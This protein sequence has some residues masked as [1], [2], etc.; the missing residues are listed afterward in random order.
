MGVSNNQDCALEDEAPDT[1]A[2]GPRETDHAWQKAVI[3]ALPSHL[4]VLDRNGR[5]VAH[6]QAWE[7][8]VLQSPH[9]SGYRMGDNYLDTLLA[10][11]GQGDSLAA[12]A[13]SGLRSV[14]NGQCPIFD[15]ET[16]FCSSDGDQR[17]YL[18]HA[19]PIR[20]HDGCVVTYLDITES[21][22]QAKSLQQAFDEVKR[23]QEQLV[24]SEKMASIGQLT[25]GVAHEINNPIGYLSSNL[26]SMVQYFDDV[27]RMVNAYEEASA[28][29]TDPEQVS[30]LQQAKRDIDI[31][32]VLDDIPKLLAES[33]EG[34][35]R[36][37][38]IVQDLKDFA[39]AGSSEDWEW[40][41]LRHSLARTLN[42][43]H[44]ELKYK[45]EVVQAYEDIP[46][47]RCL[48]GQLN[49]VFM[50]LL[51]NAAHAIEK[52][53]QVSVKTWHEGDLVWVEIADTGSGMPPEVIGRIF[54]PFFTTKPVGKGTG[55]GLSISY[56]IVKK[57]GGR[58][59]VESEV[60]RGT[61]FRIALPVNGPDG[62][63]E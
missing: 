27:L 56:G 25:A 10:L 17:C 49:Q 62:E 29:L 55:L 59:E 33:Q 28:S 26:T 46:E 45:A 4:A 43:V 24:Q 14:L 52:D 22:Q 37:R 61:R 23:T 53:G 11:A 54:E 38:K 18:M 13:T 35:K 12:Q 9:K 31:D 15:L 50:N 60:G 34:T 30:R 58:I 21:K 48:P 2:G 47:I 63:D 6:N 42:I 39:H 41:D 36:V 8:R 40:V 20:E 19:A 44:N 16:A 7:C 32:F 57:H 5:I 3:D 51:V 1:A